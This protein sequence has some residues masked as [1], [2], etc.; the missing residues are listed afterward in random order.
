VTPDDK[1]RYIGHSLTALQQQYD[2]HQEATEKLM[3]CPESPLVDPLYQVGERLLEALSLLID[4][5]FNNLTWY[6][7]ECDFGRKAKEAGARGDMRKI[8]S[9]ERLRWLVELSA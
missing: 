4:D 7:Y 1:W 2:R 3:L 9:L 8:D 6:V 5:N